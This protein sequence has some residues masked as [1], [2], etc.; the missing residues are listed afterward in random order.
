MLNRRQLLTRLAGAVIAGTATPRRGAAHAATT[1]LG[2]RLSLITSAGTNVLALSTPDGLVLQVADGEAFVPRLLAD[3]GVAVRSVSVTRPTLDD[4]FMTYTG[5]TIRD[6]ESSGP[7][8]PAM[9]RG[10]R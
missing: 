6:A 10:R 5:R 7:E 2:D 1:A 9:F 8:I 4:V 3:L